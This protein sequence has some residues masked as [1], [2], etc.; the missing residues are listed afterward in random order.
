MAAYIETTDITDNILQ[1]STLSDYVDQSDD[2]VKD[3]AE[4]KGVIDSDNIETNP[5]H[6]KIKRY[7]IAWVGMEMCSDYMGTNNNDL[8]VEIEKY[9]VKYEKYLKKV[10]KLDGKITKEMVTGTVDKASDRASSRRLY[11]G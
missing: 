1:L 7:A 5:V 9:A 10:N 2:A 11:R 6:Y 8:P 3:L 4:T